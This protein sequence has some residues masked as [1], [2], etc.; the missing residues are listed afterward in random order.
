MFYIPYSLLCI[1]QNAI[2]NKKRQRP[3]ILNP[4]RCEYFH[5]PAP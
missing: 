3:L 1:S 2:F 5:I 4:A